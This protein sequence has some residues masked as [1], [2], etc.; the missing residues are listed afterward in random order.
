M[1]RASDD[2]RDDTRLCACGDDAAQ[3]SR[4]PSGQLRLHK[5]ADSSR[6]DNGQEGSESRSALRSCLI[7]MRRSHSRTIFAYE[8]DRPRIIGM[9]GRDSVQVRLR[10][11]HHSDGQ[12]L[13]CH[14]AQFTRRDTTVNTDEWQGYNPIERNRLTVNHGAHEWA[15]YDDGNGGREV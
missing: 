12:T 4:V 14:V 11:A 7:A 3:L 13:K 10:V 5:S 6:I 1:C 2:V 15:R 9:I 8:H